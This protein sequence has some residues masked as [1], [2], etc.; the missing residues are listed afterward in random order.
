MYL[1]KILFQI[2]LDN[3]DIVSVLFVLDRI[4]MVLR[5]DQL[6]HNLGLSI[7]S[8]FSRVT[9]LAGHWYMWALLKMWAAHRKKKKKC[10]VH[11]SSFQA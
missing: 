7:I 10:L 1:Q 8:N 4:Y 11:L 3:K 6:Y 2:F 9:L 5:R